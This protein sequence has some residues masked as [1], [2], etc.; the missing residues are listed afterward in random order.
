[1][2]TSDY[3]LE[4]WS[5]TTIY[6]YA[7]ENDFELNY[8]D[9]DELLQVFCDPPAGWLVASDPKNGSE[10]FCHVYWNREDA[11]QD[12]DI[13]KEDGMV[14]I[15]LTTTVDH[16][17]MCELLQSMLDDMEKQKKHS[18]KKKKDEAKR[19]EHHCQSDIAG[20]TACA[21]ALKV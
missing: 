3:V 12:G 1:M 7:R 10:C 4:N 21:H 6:N 20:G 16:E 11:V 8:Y 19:K 14:D 13:L 15:E 18:E 17:T 5:A 2:L 9:A